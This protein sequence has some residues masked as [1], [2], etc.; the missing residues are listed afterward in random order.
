MEKTVG[1]CFTAKGLNKR[2]TVIGSFILHKVKLVI[3]IR[4]NRCLCEQEVQQ[5]W[6]TTGGTGY[7]RVFTSE[8]SREAGT[9][10]GFPFC[11]AFMTLSGGFICGGLR[12]AKS[13]P[14]AF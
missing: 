5:N 10:E 14:A 7:E 8:I 11:N 2:V 1:V 9:A 3:D 6:S 12:W 13:A 4:L